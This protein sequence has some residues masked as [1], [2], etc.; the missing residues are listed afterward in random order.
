M[1]K[2]G[3]TTCLGSL[4]RHT[5]TS[6]VLGAPPFWPCPAPP[7]YRLVPRGFSRRVLDQAP[8]SALSDTSAST[9]VHRQNNLNGCTPGQGSAILTVAAAVNGS[10]SG[11][12]GWFKSRSLKSLKESGFRC[13]NTCEQQ[14]AYKNSMKADRPW[15]CGFNVRGSCWGRDER[16]IHSLRLHTRH[17]DGARR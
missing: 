3:E 7:G 1:I 5:Q 8:P 10:W 11:F 16:Y 4:L 2:Y 17:E 13:L 14:Q 12:A 9:V 6:I 15:E